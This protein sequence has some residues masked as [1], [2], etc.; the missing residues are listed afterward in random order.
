MRLPRKALLFINLATFFL[1]GRDGWTGDWS[2]PF[3]FQETGPAASSWAEKIKLSGAFKGDF[4]WRQYADFLNRLSAPAT[5]LYIREL[6][7]GIQTDV[8][9]GFSATLVL[10][11]EWLGDDLNQGDEK[12]TVDEAHIDLGL[13]HLPFYLVL[14]KRSQAVGLFE[15]YLI[16]DPLTMDLYETKKVG[17]TAGV[18]GPLETDVSLTFYKGAGQLDHMLGS[19]L[20]DPERVLKNPLMN[21]RVSSWILAGSVTPWKHVLNVFGALFSEPG[22]SRRNMGLNMGFNF[23][24]PGHP[25]LKVDAEFMKALSREPYA[26]SDQEFKENTLSVTATYSFVLRTRR[27][28]GTGNYAGRRATARAF[29]FTAS[30]RYE[31]FDDGGLT[32]ALDAWTIRERASLGGR[33]TFFETGSALGYFQLEY[34]INTFRVPPQLAGQMTDSQNE[35]YLRLGFLF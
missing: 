16:T 15:N 2:G 6:D 9:Q 7:L 28:R 17:I 20:I 11:S 13:P 21:D 10:N 3:T 30:L 18:T 12:A 1:L 23:S 4:R 31:H 8:V 32:A 25:N 33:Y 24:L 35:V 19:G 22:T 26:G 5:D 34:R 27:F 29:P 14:G